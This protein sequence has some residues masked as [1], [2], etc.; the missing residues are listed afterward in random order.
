MKLKLL[1]VQFCFI[2][3]LFGPTF[4]KFVSILMKKYPV[5]ESL[6]ERGGIIFQTLDEI[7]DRGFCLFVCW[8]YF[9]ISCWKLLHGRSEQKLSWKF[10][11]KIECKSQ[12]NE[13]VFNLNKFS[14]HDLDCIALCFK[15]IHIYVNLEYVSWCSIIHYLPYVLN[16]YF[17]ATKEWS[18]WIPV[19][20]RRVRH[21]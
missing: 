14:S 8:F 15:R 16:S 1:F 19:Q 9:I 13:V 3:H 10:S 17:S 2:S 5:F 11:S 12:A 20:A 18:L 7:S 4:I 6:R 21:L